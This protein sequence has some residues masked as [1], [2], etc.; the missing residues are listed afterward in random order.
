MDPASYASFVRQAG[1]VAR[2]RGVE[3]VL[4]QEATRAVLEPGSIVDLWIDFVGPGGDL[5]KL[6][7]LA[8]E[9]KPLPHNMPPATLPFYRIAADDVERAVA[10]GCRVV[11]APTHVAYLD[12]PY[13]DASLDVAQEGR[14]RSLGLPVYSP[15]SVREFYEWEPDTV[16]PGLDATSIAGAKAAMWAD[17]VTDIET[18]HLLCVTRIPGFAERAWSPRGQGA[19]EE[20]APRLGAQSRVWE[21]RGLAY[22]RA[23]SVPWETRSGRTRPEKTSPP[24]TKTVTAKKETKRCSTVRTPTSRS[25]ISVSTTTCSPT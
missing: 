4:A 3:L 7:R 18:M 17:T 19:W 20:F 6:E 10:Q 2:A 21:R 5:E 8:A 22:F 11:L 25:R 12:T 24:P 15:P 9:G 1:H 14:R 16:V 13:A 23:A